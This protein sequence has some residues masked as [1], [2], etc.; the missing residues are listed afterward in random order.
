MLDVALP[1]AF[2]AHRTLLWQLCY[3]MTG[4][5]ADADDLVQETFARAV[6]R[7]PADFERDLRPWLVRVAVNLSRD[8]LRAR[9]R[10][11]YDGPYLA[12]PLDTTDW[13]TD[14]ATHPDVRYGELESVT[15][16]FLHALEA[17][18]PKQRAVL[19]LCD[20]SGYSVREAAE[21]LGMSEANVKTT[22]HRA[23]S[24]LVAYDAAR[25]PLTRELQRQTRSKLERLLWYL[26][27]RDVPALEALLAA[28]VEA[29]N[30][31]DGE[32]FAARVPVRGR[33]K[34]ALFHLKTQRHGTVHG[35]IRMLN[36]LPALVAAFQAEDLRLLTVK[37][38]Q[39]PR[40]KRVAPRVVLAIHPARDGRI[41]KIY[42]QVSSAKLRQVRFDGLDTPRWFLARTLWM[43]LRDS[44][45]GRHLAGT[46]L[47]RIEYGGRAL[48]RA[49]SAASNR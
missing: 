6:E 25:V 26:N 23:R 41:S 44:R 17:L 48:A 31:A 29:L 34:V 7:P 18:T 42:A 8:H 10:R 38:A 39:S 20:V 46:M 13:P 12:A 40:G 4:S 24:A 27:T 1:Q 30:D 21:A 32:F 28:D 45:L 15:L 47:R 22:H 16:A 2:L 35:S 49:L 11:G 33:A 43:G 14:E 9:K 19:I 36:G 3:R 37:K 5:A